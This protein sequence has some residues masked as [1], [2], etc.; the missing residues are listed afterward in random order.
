MRGMPSAMILST[1]AVINVQFG[2]TVDEKVVFSDYIQRSQAGNFIKRPLLIGVA[3]YEAGLFKTVGALSGSE[4]PEPFWT[5]LN[6]VAFNCPAAARANISYSNGVPTWRYRWF[7]DFPNTRLTSIPDSG[8]WHGSELPVLFD[9]PVTGPGIP[10]NTPEEIAIGKYFRGAWAT[11]A[12]D[13]INGLT[14][15]GGGWPNY[16]AGGQTLIRLAYQNLTGTNLAQGNMYDTNCT[17]IFPVNGSS[18]APTNP[19][20]SASSTTSTPAP[21]KTPSGATRSAVSYSVLCLIIV[22]TLLFY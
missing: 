21:T 18:T 15:Y 10:D 12:K 6:Q 9:T 7:G 4:S 16:E 19:S 1:L 14:N 17:V 22:I 3:D 2:P 11:F 8:A 5:S 20:T 13:P